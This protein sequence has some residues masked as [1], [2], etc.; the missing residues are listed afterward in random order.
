[1]QFFCFKTYSDF[2]I[3]FTLKSNDCCIV[4]KNGMVVSEGTLEELLQHCN[5]M[6]ALWN[7]GPNST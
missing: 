5:E 3:I 2:E 6:K 1:V 7:A 4:M